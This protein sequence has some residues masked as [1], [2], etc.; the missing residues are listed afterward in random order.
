MRN[1]VWTIW[2]GGG[3]SLGLLHVSRGCNY[4]TFTTSLSSLFYAFIKSAWYKAVTILHLLQIIIKLLSNVI[5]HHLYNMLIYLVSGF[6]VC[7]VYAVWFMWGNKACWWSRTEQV[8][9]IQRHQLS[10]HIER[11]GLTELFKIIP[12]LHRPKLSRYGI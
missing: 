5:K 12:R 8:S 4:L 1:Q 11:T 2:G 6:L 7:P 9:Y 10:I 3:L